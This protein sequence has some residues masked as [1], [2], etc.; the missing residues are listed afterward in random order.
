MG[1]YSQKAWEEQRADLQ[2]RLD[3]ARQEWDSC[4][5]REAGNFVEVKELRAALFQMQEA[6]KNLVAK[7]AAAERSNA[8][9]RQELERMKYWAERSEQNRVEQQK[10]L[11]ENW[12]GALGELDAEQVVCASYRERLET[13][14]AREA[15]LREALEVIVEA[16]K[17]NQMMEDDRGE[18]AYF[19]HFEAFQK[20][21]AAMAT[22]DGAK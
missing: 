21:E 11:Y 15:R 19:I 7:L 8:E 1:D 3:E 13:A 10:E 2:A 18:R 20:A 5:E 6:A 12:Q 14:Q 16:G 4:R 9:L 22:K 17:R